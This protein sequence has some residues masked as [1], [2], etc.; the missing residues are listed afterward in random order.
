MATSNLHIKN[1]FGQTIKI[2]DLPLSIDLQ[3]ELNKTT[4]LLLDVI[5]HIDKVHYEQPH[6]FSSELGDWFYDYKQKINDYK[7][8]VKQ[9]ILKKL[10]KEEQQILGL[11]PEEE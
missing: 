3:L 10:T 9:E 1:Q 4:K 11:I 5:K 8:S 6:D 2:E 7:D